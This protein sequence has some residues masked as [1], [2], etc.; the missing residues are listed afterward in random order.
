MNLYHFC[1]MRF[2]LRSSMR[3]WLRSSMRF[4][5]RSS[6]RFWLRSS[7]RF[8]L[9]SSMRFWLRSS[10]RFWLRSSMRF[11][12]RSSTRF[13]LRSCMR[14]LLINVSLTFSIKS[15][16]AK[17]VFCSCALLYDVVTHKNQHHNTFA[18]YSKC[19]YKNM[20]HVREEKFCRQRKN[21]IESDK[22]Y[23]HYFFLQK[24]SENKTACWKQLVEVMHQF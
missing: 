24:L 17:K 9:R 14:F 5:L 23:C 4:W 13:Q 20:Y 21:Y 19:I 12:F 1:L 3:L 18:Y 11:W 22:M 7:M 2:W 8:C 6:M 15:R 16:T 10:M